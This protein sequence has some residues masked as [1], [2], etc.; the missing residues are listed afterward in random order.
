MPDFRVTRADLIGAAEA[1]RGRPAGSGLTLAEGQ[2]DPSTYQ[3][4]GNKTRIP[5]FSTGLGPTLDQVK[6]SLTI[7]EIEEYDEPVT[8]DQGNVLSTNEVKKQHVIKP[9]D[10]DHPFNKGA[11]PCHTETS[12][13]EVKS[14]VPEKQDKKTQLSPISSEDSGCQGSFLSAVERLVEMQSSMMEK[15]LSM[16]QEKQAQVEVPREETAYR[17]SR[18]D[19]DSDQ[20][21][22]RD[23]QPSSHQASP[24]SD[25]KT[26]DQTTMT[27]NQSQKDLVPVQVSMTQNPAMA[28]KPNQS[29]VWKTQAGEFTCRCLDVVSRPMAGGNMII[30]VYLKGQEHLFVPVC[31]DEAIALDISHGEKGDTKVVKSSGLS[32]D[33]ELGGTEYKLVILSEVER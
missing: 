28:D 25:G 32:F 1:G 24:S 17:Q 3:T 30:V 12:Q 7:V 19:L 23:N 9:G 6:K 14:E 4:V 13:K 20:V 31:S 2:P 5:S 18:E 29:I 16:S 27:E 10:G 22:L 8:D 21:M 11:K 33:L 15:F 26:I